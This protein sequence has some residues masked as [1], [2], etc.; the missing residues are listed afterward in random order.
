[1]TQEAVGSGIFWFGEVRNI[2]DPS[3][4]G[5]IQVI[6]HG[7]D[8]VGSNPIDNS[9]LTWAIPIMNNSPSLNK[10][11]ETADYLPGSTVVGFWADFP[12][13][14]IAYIFG[15]VHKIGPTENTSNSGSGMKF[16]TPTAILGVRG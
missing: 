6:I 11:G 15:S 16:M 14:Q 5:R 7:H 13:K 12:L 2:V 4:A 10:I 9:N 8:N 1:M 3:K